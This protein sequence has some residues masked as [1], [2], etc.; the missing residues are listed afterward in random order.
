MT[1]KKSFLAGVIDN[2]W[3]GPKGRLS[4]RLKKACDDLPHQQ[5]LTVVTIMLSL[6]V[7]I[8]FIVFGHACYR[9]GARQAMNEIEVRHLGSIE[10]P[11]AP[12]DIKKIIP[13][14]YLNESAYDDAGME[15]ED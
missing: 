11:E 12:S 3:R 5:R 9:I 6:F 2:L 14:T 13:F 10:L 1:N 8:A 4:D 7:V 15:S